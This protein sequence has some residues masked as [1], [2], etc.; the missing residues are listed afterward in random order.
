MSGWTLCRAL[1]KCC[2]ALQEHL[3]NAPAGF[4]LLFLCECWAS[5]KHSLMLRF[6]SLSSIFP[7]IVGW[8]DLLFVSL[9]CLGFVFL[10]IAF[11]V[12]L[13]VRVG[14]CPFGVLS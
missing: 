9:V 4:F 5:S 7:L 12:I 2:S 10:V 1:V 6:P 8:A 11:S 3:H 14:T 13:L